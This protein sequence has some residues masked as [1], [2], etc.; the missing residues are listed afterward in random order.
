ME[1][2]SIVYTL[3]DKLYINLTNRCPC[4]CVFCLRNDQDAVGSSASL[5]LES[6]PAAARVIELLQARDLSSYREVVFCGFGEPSCALDTLLEVARWLKERGAPVRLDTNGLADLIHQRPTA[7]LLQGLIDTVSISLNASSA[8][9][10]N[11][12]CQPVFGE[13]S[14]EALLRF[15]ADCKRWVLNV[16]LSVVDVIG[17]EEIERC[18]HLAE[19]LGV[20]FRVRRE[21][22]SVS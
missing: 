12:L 14:F 22:N 7:V 13:G 21:L 6:E 1:D 9:R 4:N 3:G 11:E 19:S 10:Y 18:R 8:A 15:T 16:L 20:G 17:A 5:W 2:E